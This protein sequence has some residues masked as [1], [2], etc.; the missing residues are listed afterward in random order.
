MVIFDDAV[1]NVRRGVKDF[2]MTGGT[3]THISYSEYLGGMIYLRDD[4]HTHKK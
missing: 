4:P 1:R 2:I 3:R